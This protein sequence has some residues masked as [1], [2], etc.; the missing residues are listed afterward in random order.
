M[1]D[2]TIV[3]IRE[4]LLDKFNLII[5]KE[6]VLLI[7]KY[8]VML[9]HFVQGKSIEFEFKFREYQEAYGTNH[10]DATAKFTAKDEPITPIF[11]GKWKL[12]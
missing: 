11:T 6:E 2:E 12:V 10:A 3:L 7:E 9:C 8:P 5:T 4:I 1:Y